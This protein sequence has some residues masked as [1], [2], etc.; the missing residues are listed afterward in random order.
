V[1]LAGE[2]MPVGPVF[3]HKI[4]QPAHAEKAR[5]EY[6]HHGYDP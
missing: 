3:V 1:F 2:V 4:A 6:G 5:P